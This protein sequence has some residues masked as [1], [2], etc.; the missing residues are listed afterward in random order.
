MLVSVEKIKTFFEFILKQ[1]I[2]ICL[3]EFVNTPTGGYS[4]GI[5]LYDTLLYKKTNNNLTA[6]NSYRGSN[7]DLFNGLIEW[8]RQYDKYYQVIEIWKKTIYNSHISKEDLFLWRCQAFELLCIINPLIKDKSISLKAKKQANP[9]LKNF[10]T[11]V[12]D[13]YKISTHLDSRYFRDLK[14]VRDK[15]THNNPHKKISEDQKSNS[16]DLIEHFFVKTFSK[17][18]NIK[19]MSTALGLK[20]YFHSDSI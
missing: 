3:I 20:P 11:A 1:E 19:G 9:N 7:D 12:S 2:T 8:I 10:L 17:V 18:N 16:Y 14:D 5:L 13:I 15:L 6:L 4:R